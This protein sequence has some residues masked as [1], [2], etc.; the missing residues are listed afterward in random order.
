MATN[1]YV[2][3]EINELKVPKLKGII[4]LQNIFFVNDC[5]EAKGIKSFTNAFKRSETDQCYGARS[6]SGTY[7]LKKKQDFQPEQYEPFSVLNKYLSYCEH[8]QNVLKINIKKIKDPKSK[9]S[10]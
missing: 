7:Q 4:T 3:R 1:A 5:L 8:L 9:N 6:E 2:S 10:S